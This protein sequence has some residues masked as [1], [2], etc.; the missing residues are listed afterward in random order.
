MPTAGMTSVMQVT[1]RG[2]DAG[3]GTL[4]TTPPLDTVYGAPVD[5]SSYPE[6]SQLQYEVFFNCTNISPPAPATQTVVNSTP[7][8]E[9]IWFTYRPAD[10]GPGWSSWTGN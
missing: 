7:I 5:L 2:L 4:W 3:G 8:F 1:V 6:V 10:A 9:S